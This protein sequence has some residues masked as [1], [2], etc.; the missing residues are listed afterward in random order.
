MRSA[1]LLAFIASSI[2]AVFPLSAK[3]ANAHTVTF[4]NQRGDPKDSPSPSPGTE[5]ASR[6]YT[7]AINGAL[8]MP[9]GTTWTYDGSHQLYPE[10]HLFIKVTGGPHCPPNAPCH[11]WIKRGRQIHRDAAWEMPPE[12]D[13]APMV[14]YIGLFSK[15]LDKN[16]IPEF[17]GVSP[18]R[19]STHALSRQV[20]QGI[21]DQLA[22]K[23]AIPG[24]PRIESEKLLAVLSSS[25][26]A[27]VSKVEPQ[28]QFIDI[29][30][31]L[32]L[33]RTKIQ[34]GRPRIKNDESRKLRVI[35]TK[36]INNIFGSPGA[37]IAYS[38]IPADSNKLNNDP[39]YFE[40]IGPNPCTQ[41]DPCY[42]LAGKGSVIFPGI[43]AT[44]QQKSA[45]HI[46]IGQ[47][48]W[49][50]KSGDTFR[51]DIIGAYP[52]GYY[53]PSWPAKQVALGEQIKHMLFEKRTQ[54]GN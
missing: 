42:G 43:E 31:G 17:M 2:L 26:Q 25:S 11:G 46:V 30:S 7:K 1:L 15:K 54:I 8:N 40:F 9:K 36:Q 20:W 5:S 22:F 6:L 4:I 50:K 37:F 44:V 39:V 32:P 18:T 13:N 16:G 33:G 12:S 23:S 27:S 21:H 47:P 24:V 38:G 41:S 35:M 3:R 45:F 49:P 19:V 14:D 51:L 53:H 29:Q 10:G 34:S 28:V 48:K 52:K